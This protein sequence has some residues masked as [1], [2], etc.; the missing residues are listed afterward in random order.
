MNAMDQD[1]T[2]TL[3]LA[4]GFGHTEIVKALIEKGAGVNLVNKKD[5]TAL[6]LA[7]LTAPC[8]RG[9]AYQCWSEIGHTLIIKLYEKSHEFIKNIQKRIK[10]IP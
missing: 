5:E 6:Y 4:G 8:D 10:I 1:G 9:C 2:T 7:N 3:M